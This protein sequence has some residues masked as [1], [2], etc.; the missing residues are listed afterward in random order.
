MI[1]I[2]H[3]IGSLNNGGS[4]A[5]VMNLYRN[6]DKTKI[7]FD[8]IIDRENELFFADE[9]T[10]LGGKIHVLPSFKGWNITWYLKAW[11][12]FFK[13]HSEYRIIHGHVRSTASIYLKIAKMYRLK[14]I[15]HSHSTSSGKGLSAVVKNIMQYPIRYFAD[16]FFACSKEAGEWLFGKKILSKKNFFV[17]K[18]AIDTK[19]F[20]FSNE[21]RHQIREE[22]NISNNFVIGHVGRFHPTKNHEFLVEVFYEVYKNEPSAKLMLVG[23]G[24]EIEY[25]KEK[26][27]KLGIL[28]NIIFVGVSSDVPKLMQAMDA[29]VFPSLYEGLGIVVIEAQASGLFCVVADT[30]PK[31]TNISG[32]VEFISLNESSIYWAGK[33]LD[34]RN[35]YKR[36]NLVNE[37]IQSGYD[38]KQTSYWLQRFY[39]EMCE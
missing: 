18:N 37:L 11:N 32:I 14:T 33:I 16:Y 34:L 23:D 31:D 9:I 2:L 24:A 28:N 1:R 5:M 26:S 12:K 25:I 36:T 10:A 4:Q 35:N 30:I 20:I 29:F 3:V 22:Y 8:F 13:D 27:S 38:I 21:I 6:I 19:K 17:F 7:Q 39:L 15:S